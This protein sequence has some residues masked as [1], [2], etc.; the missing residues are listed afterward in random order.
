MDRDRVGDLG[1]ADDRGHVEVGLGRGR[2]ADAD[3]LV[4]EQ[5]V[6]QIVVDRGVH[7][8]GL[9]A[10]FAAGAQDSQSDFAAVGNDDFIEHRR[11]VRS[12]CGA[13]I[14]DEQDLPVLDRFAVLHAYRF[15]RSGNL[16]LDLV[17]HFHGFDD[18]QGIADPDPISDLDKRCRARGGR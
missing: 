10:H 1:G 17:H 13:L 11:R 15:D 9:D 14:D 4:G 16:G 12:L 18:A 2:T 7:R 8:D 5:H 3:G 6:L